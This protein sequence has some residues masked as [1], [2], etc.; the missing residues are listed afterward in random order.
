MLSRL[1]ITC[2]CLLL[3]STVLLSQ[4]VTPIQKG[5]SIEAGLQNEDVDRYSLMLKSG[6]FVNGYVDQIT[7]DV[8]I[9]VLDPEGDL[10]ATFDNP[11][12]GLE[13][14]QFDSEMRGEYQIEVTPFEE[15]EG[16]YSIAI[17]RIEATANTPKERVDQLLAAYDNE[18]T[19]G[20]VV[21]VFQGGEI[22]FINAYGMAN[23]VHNI[24]WNAKMT[25]NIG[26]VSKQFTAMAILLLEESGA[27]NLDHDIRRY[28]PELPDFGETVTIRHLLTHT[29]GYREMYNTMPMRGWSGEDFLM[30]EEAIGLI[31][32]QP[33]LQASPGEEFRYNNTSFV[34][35]ATLVERITEQDFDEWMESN[36]FRALGMTN[37]YVRTNPQQIIPNSTQGYSNASEGGF[38]EAGDLHAAYGAGGIYTTVSDLNK[39][40]IN[41]HTP[42]VGSAELIEKLVT[43]YILNDGESTEYGLGIGVTEWRGLTRYAHGGADIAH[44][45]FL[46]YFPEIDAGVCVM[47]NN[48]AFVTGLSAEIAEAFFE[49]HLEEEEEEEE[50]TAEEEEGMDGEISLSEEEMKPYTGRF[51]LEEA[52][53]I[54]DYAIEEGNLQATASGQPTL[55]LEPIGEHEFEYEMIEARVVFDVDDAGE[56][57]TATHFQGGG[58]FSLVRIPA[59]APTEEELQEFVGTYFSDELQTAYTIV[60]EEGELKARHINMEEIALSPAEEDTFSGSVFFIGELAF[61]RSSSGEVTGFSLSNGRTRGVQFK[62]WEE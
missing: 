61:L 23:L 57:N 5:I 47:S 31:Q 2:V 7:V 8:V 27:L 39:W 37:T 59:Y 20:A 29:N 24:P 56:I 38:E 17:D 4:D 11:A 46:M 13:T 10:V 43:P 53:L 60:V 40:L 52:G 6:S 30:R 1:L 14:F 26:S 45:A 54:I 9:R 55:I 33:E 51:K 49:E 25:T 50:D 34:L 22:V 18:R 21:G 44:R 15:E 32:R 35:L 19:P 16:N 62:R 58:E 28:I 42:R 48:S 36:V 12:R 41:F 3:T